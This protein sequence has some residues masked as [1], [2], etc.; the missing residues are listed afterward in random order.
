M[1]FQVEVVQSDIFSA[2]LAE[3]IGSLINQAVN[4]RGVCTISL[5]GGSTPGAIYRAMTKSPLAQE[6]P[7]KK[8]KIF[9]GDE[10]WVPKVSPQSNY[11]MVEETLL[12][13]LGEQLPMLFHLNFDSPSASQAAEEYE[14]T[15]S[16]EVTDQSFDLILL[17]L[18][19]D[20]HFASIF[21]GSDYLTEEKRNVV[22]TLHPSGQERISFTPGLIKKAR[23]V[24]FLVTG[25]RKASIVKRLFDGSDTPQ[26]LPARLYIQKETLQTQVHWFLDAESA[27]KLGSEYTSPS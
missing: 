10:R 27:A 13:P 11:H 15:I 25:E 24:L 12:R 7:W 4:L 20:G 16:K 23:K 8:V 22:S 14:K 6:I 1:S 9:F 26:D 21:P 18:G 19:E 17:G 2:V 3:E 5:A